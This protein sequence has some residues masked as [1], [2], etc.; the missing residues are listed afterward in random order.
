VRDSSG[1]PSGSADEPIAAASR[2]DPA[3]LIVDDDLGA[4]EVLTIALTGDGYRVDGCSSARDAL[5]HLRSHAD[6]GVILLDLM[7]PIIAATQFRAAQ[8]RDRSLAWIPV[9]VMSAA[10][11]A[12]RDA[13]QLG[14]RAFV[15]KPIDLD[16]LKATIRRVGGL[17]TQ[18]SGPE[19]RRVHHS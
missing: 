4:R 14:A 17:P 8:L 18:L 9:I 10:V 5:N 16:Q 1:R 3:V 13:E 2:R 19:P 12:A 11:D 15:R 7:V 6:I